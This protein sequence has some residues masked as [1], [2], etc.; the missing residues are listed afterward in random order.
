MVGMGAND[1]MLWVVVQ[2]PLEGDEGLLPSRFMLHGGKRGWVAKLALAEKMG[3]KDAQRAA[4]RLAHYSKNCQAY[5]IPLPAAWALLEGA[6]ARWD[7][8]PKKDAMA[9]KREV[10]VGQK[11]A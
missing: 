11:A 1:G 9:T 5:A 4:N 8:N 10:L 3:R 6:A 7:K 2:M